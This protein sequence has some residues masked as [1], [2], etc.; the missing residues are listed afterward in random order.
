DPSNQGS[1]GNQWPCCCCGPVCSIAS[2]SSLFQIDPN[3]PTDPATLASSTSSFSEGALLYKAHNNRFD[4]A[5][6]DGH[7]E[8]LKYEDTIGSGTL[9]NPAGMWTAK[10]GD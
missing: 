3:A 8:S 6:H 4:Y 2:W 5:F 1:E 9:L 7:V 10:G